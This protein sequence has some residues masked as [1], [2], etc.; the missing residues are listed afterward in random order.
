MAGHK[1]KIAYEI[2]NFNKE[3]S[4]PQINYGTCNSVYGEIFLAT[5]LKGICNL[6]FMIHEKNFYLENLLKK[7][8]KSSIKETKE[9]VCKLAKKI[10]SQ[11][12]EELSLH[13]KG[14]KFQLKVWQTLLT[15]PENKLYSY[16]E[17]AEL[18]G[19]PCSVR[20]A[21]NAIAKNPVHYLIP[22]HKIIRKDGSLGGYA[23]GIHKKKLI[24][25]SENYTKE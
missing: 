15:L 23:G 24:L 5:T 7:W 9:Q 21:A 3:N 22:C 8:K 20:A 6:Q 25:S 13:L 10:F 19:Y 2:V 14:T 18:A 16:Q 17:L 11:E 4:A 1:I 12:K